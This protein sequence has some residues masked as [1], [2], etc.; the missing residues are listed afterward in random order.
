[1]DT[2][3]KISQQSTYKLIFSILALVLIGYRFFHL[4]GVI[5]DPHAWRQ[6][7]TANYIYDFYKN[8]IDLFHPAVCWMGSYKTVIFE[9]PLPEAIVACFWMFFGESIF[10]ARIVFLIFFLGAAY[11]FFRV[12][13]RLYSQE[14]AQMSSILFLVLPLSLH[15]SRAIHIDFFALFLSLGMFYYFLKAFATSKFRYWSVAILFSIPAFMVKAPYAFFLALPL[16]I[17]L[18]KSERRLQFI[19]WL[20]TLLIPILIFYFWQRYVYHINGLAPDWDYINH[21]R[22]FDNNSN[23]YFGS[24]DQRLS[25]RSWKILTK[26]VV[27]EVATIPGL[28]LCL[29]G[30]WIMLKKKDFFLTGWIIGLLIYLLVFFNLNI[31][32]N[33]YQIPMVPATAILIALGISTLAGKVRFKSDRYSKVLNISILLI[34]CISSI[35]FA[36]RNYF[37]TQDQKLYYKIGNEIRSNTEET[38]LVI[39][40]YNGFDCRNPMLLF[41]SRRNGWSIEENGLSPNIIN[42]LR[43]EE[44]ADYWVVVGEEPPEFQIGKGK[45]IELEGEQKKLYLYDLG[46]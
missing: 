16:S 34:V 32:H 40:T 19:K 39:I 8:G 28:L 42:R 11:Y 12:V 30:L 15:Y 37:N 24:L 29:A 35:L 7:D 18:F 5:D 22:K 46:D 23:W 13:S 14:V 4:G 41:P 31:V 21:Y 25:L 26:R 38:D 9:F 43:D 3:S 45:E 36:D 27:M 20:P 2:N 33:Y 44:G 6:S 10:V 1:M 17:L